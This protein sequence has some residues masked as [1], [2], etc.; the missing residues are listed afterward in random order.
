MSH[1]EALQ[2]VTALGFFS[3]HVDGLVNELSSFGVVPLGPVVAGAVLAEDKVV[4]AEE[5]SEG[6]TSDGVHDSGFEVAQDCSRNVATSASLIKVNIGSLELEVTVSLVLAIR[7]NAVFIGD[8]FPE[9]AAD[10]VAALANLNVNDFS[11]L[12]NVS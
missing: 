1:L 11:H 3:D 8:H 6:T 12:L 7:V 5:L 4:G 2:A 10:L 9:L